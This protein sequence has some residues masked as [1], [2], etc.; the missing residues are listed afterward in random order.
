M[1][2]LSFSNH[3]VVAAIGINTEKLQFILVYKILKSW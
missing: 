1:L 3:N 2:I